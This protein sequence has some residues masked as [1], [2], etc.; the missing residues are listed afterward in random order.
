MHRNRN[1]QRYVQRCDT[2]EGLRILARMIARDLVKLKFDLDKHGYYEG[3]GLHL[4]ENLKREI[5][6]N[7]IKDT[8]G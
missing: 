8:N 1:K 2:N 7:G 6:N 4:P 5:G 3:Y